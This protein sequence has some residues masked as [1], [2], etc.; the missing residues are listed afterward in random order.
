MKKYFASLFVVM[1]TTIAFSQDNDTPEYSGENFSLEGAI[2]LFKK[3][4]TLE[5]FEEAINNEKN[6]VNNLDLNNDGNIDYITVEDVME[7]D[8]HI[9]VLTALLGEKDKQD[10]ATITVEKTG[11]EEAQLQ[12]IGDEDLYAENTIAEP[13]D[14]NEKTDRSKNGPAMPEILTTRI[15]VNVWGW[16]TVRFLYAPGYRIWVSP[17]RWAVYPRWWKPWRPIR[18]TIFVGRCHPHKVYVHRTSVR[19]VS[20]HKTYGPRRHS[21]TMVVKSK[22]RTTVVHKGRRGNVKAVRVRRR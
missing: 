18:H 4:N 11:N 8:K 9:I 17:V 1:G 14:V 2:S 21:S 15:V 13:F 5:Q 3:A 6:D 12:I 7:D 10:V 22:K 19:R 16:P 20:L